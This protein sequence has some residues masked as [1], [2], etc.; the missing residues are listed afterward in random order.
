MVHP[1]WIEFFKIGPLAN[2]YTTQFSTYIL[3]VDKHL[4]WKR[5]I[6]AHIGFEEK[7]K[8]EK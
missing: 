1:V 8:L 6:K 3:Y 4:I 7:E 2:Y 5:K